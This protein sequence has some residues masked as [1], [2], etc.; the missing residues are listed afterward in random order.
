MCS[1]RT[2]GSSTT[3]TSSD[4][5]RQRLIR[6]CRKTLDVLRSGNEKMGGA[7]QVYPEK[8]AMGVMLAAFLLF[9]FRNDDIW[10][11]RICARGNWVFRLLV[12][13]VPGSGCRTRRMLMTGLGGS[14]ST[15]C[16]VMRVGLDDTDFA[17]GFQKGA[18]DLRQLIHAVDAQLL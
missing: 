3:G 17:I 5:R 11:K 13:V 15:A 9:V 1:G 6:I 14:A 4:A 16:A 10:P 12:V 18:L 2:V 8:N 7:A